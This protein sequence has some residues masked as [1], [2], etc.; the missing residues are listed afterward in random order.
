MKTAVG[1][2]AVHGRGGFPGTAIPGSFRRDYRMEQNR[3]Y[4]RLT[5]RAA[6]EQGSVISATD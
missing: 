4:G 6:H 1:T 2:M 3:T 5:G